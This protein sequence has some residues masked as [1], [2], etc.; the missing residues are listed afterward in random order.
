[1]NFD[2]NVFRFIY[3]GNGNKIYPFCKNVTYKIFSVTF[4][5]FTLQVRHLTHIGNFFLEMMID[6]YHFVPNRHIVKHFLIRG[7]TFFGSSMLFNPLTT[8][9]IITQYQK[10]KYFILIF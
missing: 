3:L 8:T 4:F 9:L 2:Y 1:M 6:Q 10:K 5:K 7:L